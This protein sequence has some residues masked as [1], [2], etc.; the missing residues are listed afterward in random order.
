MLRA[1]T[2]IVNLVGNLLYSLVMLLDFVIARRHFA[3]VPW[4]KWI[5]SISENKTT[6]AK[7]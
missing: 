1:P 3:S 2:P 7:N 5:C 4:A 6:H